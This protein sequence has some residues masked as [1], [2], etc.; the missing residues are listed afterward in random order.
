MD[1]STCFFR[2]VNELKRFFQRVAG[3]PLYSRSF[4]GT[5]LKARIVTIVLKKHIDDD[6]EHAHLP[7][8]IQG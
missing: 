5:E 8:G 4:D 7:R 3:H 2:H 1:Y 6:Q